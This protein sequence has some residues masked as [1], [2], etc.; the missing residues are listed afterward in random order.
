[1]QRRLFSKNIFSYQVILAFFKIPMLLSL[2]RPILEHP[3]SVKIT[4]FI[5]FSQKHL[6]DLILK[7]VTELLSYIVIVQLFL[8]LDLE[9]MF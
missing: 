1:M 9:G 7:V 6:W 5:L 3:L 2:I 8:F 4:G